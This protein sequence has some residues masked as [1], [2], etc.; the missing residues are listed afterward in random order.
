MN[1]NQLDGDNLDILRRHVAD[2]TV[3]LVYISPF[4]SNQDYN[5]LFAER[6]GTRAAAQIKTKARMREFARAG[7]RDARGAATGSVD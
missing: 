2:E 7:R 3:D 4:K 6:D 5:V 1:A